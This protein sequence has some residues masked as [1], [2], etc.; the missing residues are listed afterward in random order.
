[1]RA[2][3]GD[4]LLPAT[5]E[6]ISFLNTSVLPGLEAA[7]GVVSTAARTF[8][9]LPGP[10]KA[11]TAALVAFKI[12]QAT[13]L[14]S[15]AASG[16]SSLSNGL[17]SLRLRA[18]LAAD[19]Y[20]QL[21]AGQVQVI[22]GS[23]T[24]TP[25]VGRMASALG[26]LQTASAG[27]GTGLKRGLSGA[28]SLIGGPWGAA[29][30]VGTL[31]VAHFWREHQKAKQ[32]VEDFTATLDKQ[33]G[34]LTESS[35]EFAAKALLDEGV[36]KSADQLG[37]SLSSV[38]DAALD[39]AGALQTLNAE[40]DRI[41][42]SRP[43]DGLTGAFDEEDVTAA[44]KL[45][46]VVND[47]NG[48]V[49]KGIAQQKLFGAA[50]GETGADAA[51]TAQQTSGYATTIEEARGAVQKLLD[52]E[53]ERRN[54]NRSAFGD[55]TA[56]AQALSDARVEAA[57]GAKTLDLNTQ[58]GRDNR[59][60]LA[61]LADQWSNSADAVKN[62]RGA[63][64][65]FRQQFITIATQMGIGRDRAKELA[66]RLLGIPRNTPAAVTTPGMDKALADLRAY[67][68]LLLE[69]RTMFRPIVAAQGVKNRGEIQATQPNGG[70]P[71]P[72][73]SPGA[74]TTAPNMRTTNNGPAIYVENQ[75][76]QPQ[77]YDQFLADQ[78][79]RARRAALDG[80]Q[81]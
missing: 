39:E 68:A 22:N 34:A 72:R 63:Y 28:L 38:T 69:I 13:G 19:S 16:F 33:T 50:L 54:A 4:K 43:T 46:G 42:R 71:A 5:S 53:N 32:R 77:S 59:N 48:V 35:R 66:D 6:F 57:E 47:T 58:A 64:E 74:G 41:A 61:D 73:F 8:N 79:N 37:I 12:A 25:A 65:A 26:A 36:L 70:A 67:K 81:R 76:V 3:L 21:R 18:M 31:A 60:A 7:G 75:Y 27:A 40:L 24:F 52:V 78:N 9:E 20:N 10:I 29:L 2:E 45:K 14:S 11:A 44:L 15:S 51:K 80:I 1:M 62:S 30:A 55:R 49:Q 56:L 17:D 23:G